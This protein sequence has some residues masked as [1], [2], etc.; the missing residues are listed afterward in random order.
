MNATRLEQTKALLA[1]MTSQEKREVLSMLWDDL[2]EGISG[3]IKTPGVCG[4]T[5]RIVRSRIPVWLLV[6]YR[7]MG[8]DEDRLL[9]FYP[10]LTR[11]DLEQAWKY[12]QTYKEEIDQEIAQQEEE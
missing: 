4:G 9:S 2:N 10:T 5:A 11:N 6:S 7:N 8:L 1:N 3:V 12:Y